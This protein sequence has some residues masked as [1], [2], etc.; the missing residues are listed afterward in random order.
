MVAT[1]FDQDGAHTP[2]LAR[3]RNQSARKGIIARKED[4]LICESIQRARHS[5][6]VDSQFYS[7]FWDAMHYT[8]N[9]LIMDKLE[10]GE[11]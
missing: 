11:K 4:N 6:A 5:P 7:P 2:E 10:A 9:N 1:M 3:D 8:L